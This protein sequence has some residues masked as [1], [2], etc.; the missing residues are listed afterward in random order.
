MKV[1]C[2]DGV[3][4]HLTVGKE[5][6]VIEMVL[7]NYIVLNDNGE[8]IGWLRSRFVVS[9]DKIQ[10]DVEEEKCWRAMRPKDPP[11]FCPCGVQKS[12]CDYHR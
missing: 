7:E 4:G 9:E 6:Q 10:G 8:K 11:G 2:K 1:R 5:Y 12:M 3:F